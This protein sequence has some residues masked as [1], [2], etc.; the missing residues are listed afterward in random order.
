V[1][2]KLGHPVEADND[3]DYKVHLSEWD[4]YMRLGAVMSEVPDIQQFGI[5]AGASPGTA[6]VA[7]MQGVVSAVCRCRAVEVVHNCILRC[8]QVSCAAHDWTAALCADLSGSAAF[9]HAVYGR[10]LLTWDDGQV[11]PWIAMQLLGCSL[12]SL[13]GGHVSRDRT[14]FFRFANQMLTVSCAV[15]MHHEMHNSCQGRTSRWCRFSCTFETTSSRG[16]GSCPTKAHC[17]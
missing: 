4:S 3:P 9:L 2:L 7:C 6:A 12:E 11:R 5:A 10:G 16:I 14:L 13:V 1:A 17:K 8:D 15:N